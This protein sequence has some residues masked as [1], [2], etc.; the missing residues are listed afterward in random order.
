MVK[1]WLSHRGAG[2]AAA[3][4][5]GF[6]RAFR[7]SAAAARGEVTLEEASD[8]AARLMREM[9]RV[10]LAYAAKLGAAGEAAGRGVS[11]CFEGLQETFGE[12]LAEMEALN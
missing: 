11:R 4:A 7:D 5:K 8:L 6:A 9:S 3:P 10:E 1:A 12:L 2:G